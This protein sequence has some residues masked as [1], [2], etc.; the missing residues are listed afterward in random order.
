[1]PEIQNQ[2]QQPKKEKKNIVQKTL[3]PIT[4]TLDFL[5]KYFKSIIFLLILFLIF[6]SMPK[7]ALVPPNLMKVDLKGTILDAK[8]VLDQIEK[9]QKPNIKGVLFVV[10]SPGGAVAPAIEISRAIK[11]LKKK[12]P[13]ITY[14]AGTLASGSYY[15]SIWSDKI[16]ANPGSIIGSIGV[17][18]EQ[19]NLKGLL[20]KIGI[21]PQVVKAGKYKEAGTP[22]RPWKPYEREELQKVIDNTYEMFVKDV[23]KARGLRYADREKFA[24]AHIFTAMQ[25]KKV[26]LIDEVGTI[27]DAQKELER[28]SGVKKAVWSKE[29][30]FEH[31]F[32]QLSGEI[33]MKLASLL[34]GLQQF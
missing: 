28:R 20:D 17:I 3:S 32:K 12:K 22:F 33:G 10:D 14:A 16:I 23:C 19:P 7:E 6:A 9:A 24:E 1:M 25:A 13:V 29:S 4:G 21:E 34:F 8:G 11:R 31:F 2:E 5:Q 18:M 30:P 15:A 27:Y 26:G